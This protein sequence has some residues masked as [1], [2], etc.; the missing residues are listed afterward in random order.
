MS[1][2]IPTLS[3]SAYS[4]SA[5]RLL[6]L[7]AE[8]PLESLKAAANEALEA[9]SRGVAGR[10]PG[11]LPWLPEVRQDEATLKRAIQV[12]SEAEGRMRERLFWPHQR[13]PADQEALEAA[14][15]GRFEVAVELWQRAWKEE[16]GWRTTAA[17]NLAVF[18]HSRA[19]SAPR[20]PAA[21]LRDFEQARIWWRHVVAGGRLEPL[22]LDGERTE[23]QI[24]ELRGGLEKWISQEFQDL[25]SPE[26]KGASGGGLIP[27]FGPGW[28]G[29]E[30]VGYENHQER[31]AGMLIAL[32]EAEEAVRLGDREAVMAAIH[33]AEDMAAL[34]ADIRAVEEARCRLATRLVCRG[35]KPVSR[36]PLVVSFS[37]MGTALVGMEK[38]DPASYSYET[39]LMFIVGHLPVLPL[40]RYRVR[41][42]SDGSPEFLGRLPVDGLTLTHSLLVVG[43][44]LLCL[45][46]ASHLTQIHGYRLAHLLPSG[47]SALS[48][49]AAISRQEARDLESSREARIAKLAELDQTLRELESEQQRLSQEE[50]PELERMLAWATSHPRADS[51]Q[52]REVQE[53]KNRIEEVHARLEEIPEEIK[54]IRVLSREIR[55]LERS[56]K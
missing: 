41:Q 2:R 35:L 46:G 12:L 10:P 7:S 32:E 20:G 34:P 54:S 8:K 4:R 29:Q 5:F 25:L 31:R 38:V 1:S 39:R 50:L 16:P 49:P 19:L 3:E 37:G 24:M 26:R 22:F 30:Y 44:L 51:S 14:R 13:T 15:A 17:H 42:S 9:A 43:S 55:A 52:R 53:L 18:Y 47:S 23:E 33:A 48:G 11:D 6:G 36:P 56:L 28:I 45:W 21:A 27:L 40:G